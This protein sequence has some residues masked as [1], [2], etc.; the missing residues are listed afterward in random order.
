[1]EGVGSNQPVGSYYY[2]VEDDRGVTFDSDALALVDEDDGGSGNFAHE[3]SGPTCLQF[4]GKDVIVMSAHGG[5]FSNGLSFYYSSISRNG[6]VTMYDGPNATGNVL[7]SREFY[8]LGFTRR[9][10][11]PTGDFNRWRGIGVKFPG[12]A[13]SVLF[14]GAMNRMLIDDITIGSATSRCPIHGRA[15]TFEL[16]NGDSD[17]R[18]GPIVDGGS[19][20]LT[21]NWNIRVKTSHEMDACGP[22]R[23]TFFPTGRMSSLRRSVEWVPFYFLFGDN[24]ITRDVYGNTN[25]SPKVSTVLLTNG[26]YYCIRST[27]RKVPG[28]SQACFKHSCQ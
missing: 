4:Y 28:H 10:G 3:P 20:C 1:M 7:A 27:E 26:A 18:V 14:S 2:F 24:P 23:I 25:A 16:W 13:Q 9:D 5:G 6:S 17:S 21:G 19:Y 12:I 8:P 22:I 15:S 11:D